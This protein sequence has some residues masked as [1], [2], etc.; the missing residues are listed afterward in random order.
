MSRTSTEP[1]VI[2]G[3]GMAGLS[4]ARALAEAGMQSIVLDKGRGLG[5]RMATRRA[6]DATFDHGAQ[7]FTAKSPEFQ[8]LVQE[9]TADGAVRAWC[10]GFDGQQGHPRFCGAEGMTSLPKWMARGLDVRRSSQV[11]SITRDDGGWRIVLDGSDPIDARAVIVTAPVPQALALIDSVPIETALL[12]RLRDVRYHPCFSLMVELDGPSGL[13]PPG[14]LQL[15]PPEPIAWVADNSLKGVSVPAALTIHAGPAFSAAHY[16]DAPDKVIA[17]MMKAA[18]PWLGGSEARSV[19]LHRW[20]YSLVATEW[21]DEPFALASEEPPLLLAGDAF[22]S[23]R[24][25]GAFLSGRA[26]ALALIDR[27]RA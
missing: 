23:G 8:A 21:K 13:R 11:K 10:N 4:A 3:A 24:V 22:H 25:E 27:L 26:A 18:A 2:I 20:R 5:G 15:A 7:H 12:E 1:V 19:Q 16:D 14:G 6:G 9:A 17:L